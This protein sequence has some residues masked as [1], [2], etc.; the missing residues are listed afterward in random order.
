MRSEVGTNCQNSSTQIAIV[1]E[2]FSEEIVKK[3]N[4]LICKGNL[5]E[6][7]TEFDNLNLIF[8]QKDKNL[9]TAYQK[10][11]ERDRTISE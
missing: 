4:S 11:E 1:N 7:E 6:S 10:I 5:P 2:F 8:K 3:F 9:N